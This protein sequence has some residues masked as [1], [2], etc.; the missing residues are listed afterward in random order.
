LQIR[1]HQ[2]LSWLSDVLGRHNHPVAA[3]AIIG[4]EDELG[5]IEA[6]LERVQDGPAALVRTGEPGIGKTVLWE[7][8]VEEAR[9]RI[10][11]VL[12][13]RGVEAEASLSFAG[14]SELL[15]PV[16]EEALPSLVP[17]RREALE[18]ALLLVRPG[19]RAPDAHAIGLAVLDM[20]RALTGSGRVLVALDDSQWLDPASAGAIQIAFRRLQD[21][22]IGCLRQCEGHRTWE[23]RSSSSDR[24][25]RG[26]SSG[27]R[28]ARSHSVRCTDC[29]RSGS[30]SS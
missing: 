25:R 3:G 26:D 20:L 24:S 1:R 8:G 10:D 11:R 5:T 6:F 13:C 14:L 4:R 29:S 22:S 2:L 23:S 9:G 18:V 12:T 19:D 21:E 30:G 17:P 15:A 28:S 7:A 27:S 16:L